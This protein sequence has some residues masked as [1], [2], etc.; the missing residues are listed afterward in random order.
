M[1][2]SSY[3]HPLGPNAQLN[4]LFAA[5]DSIRAKWVAMTLLAVTARPNK[6]QFGSYGED[7]VKYVNVNVNVNVQ[8]PALTLV[9]CH[10]SLTI[11][12]TALIGRSS[13]GAK[14]C[15]S[16]QRWCQINTLEVDM[17]VTPPIMHGLECRLE[18]LEADET[19]CMS[20]VFFHFGKYLFF[21]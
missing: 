13:P 14:G 8:N 5:F 9:T 6:G 2:Q 17:Y 1:D 12:W 15:F 21:G 19:G 4:A 16:Y 18:H 20:M 10:T 11:L 7:M 3:H